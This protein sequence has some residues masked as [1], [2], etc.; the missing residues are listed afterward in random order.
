[1]M[2]FLNADKLHMQKLV[3]LLVVVHVLII[4]LVH[5]DFDSWPIKC[6]ELFFALEWKLD[7]KLCNGIFIL[8]GFLDISD[9][10]G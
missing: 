5:D 8:K 4:M 6:A 1:M 3:A 10:H 7:A 9:L 2:G